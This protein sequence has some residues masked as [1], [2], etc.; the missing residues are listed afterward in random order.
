MTP[1]TALT[2]RTPEPYT[3]LETEENKIAYVR[4]RTSM[5]PEDKRQMGARERLLM[6]VSVHSM[7]MTSSLGAG[8]R[9]PGPRSTNR[10][11]RL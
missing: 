9:S 1:A 7:V 10:G 5:L 2:S 11:S 6:G 8:P 3:W 4:A